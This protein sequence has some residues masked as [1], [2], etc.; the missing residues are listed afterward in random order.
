MSDQARI[1]PAAGGRPDSLADLLRSARESRGLSLADVAEL[2]H[3]RQEYLR[4]LEEGRYGDLPEDVY[5]R[6]FVRLFAQAVGVDVERA[7]S[8]Y[9]LERKQAGGLTTLEMRLEQERRG[10]KPP[11]RRK[12]R[13]ATDRDRQGFSLGPLVPTLVL[14]AALV[15]LAV[16]GFNR[17]MTPGRPGTSTQAPVVAPQSGAPAG[18]DAGAADEPEAGQPATVLISVVSEPP[19]ATVTI[20]SFALPG[21]TPIRDVPV[22]ARAGRVLNVTLDGYMPLLETVDL[23]D[24]Q[25][26]SVNLV[27]APVAETPGG[28]APGGE[29]PAA[30]Q[31]A[32]EVTAPTWLEVYASTARNQ[33][34]RL[35]YRTAQAGETFTFDLPVYVHVGNAAGV[36]VTQGDTLIGTLGSA[37]SVLG[38]AFTAQ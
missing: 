18:S 23:L 4:A 15:G 37:G 17:L 29:A 20:D 8:A 33:G 28:E 7:M 3:V 31:L 36:Q 1:D 21:T 27:P 19:G 38:R 10:E 13:S 25:V 6:N 22:T 12:R 5:A 16:W 9:Q 30:D 32:I 24:D 2:T 11:R 34:E 26:L 35:V 14:V